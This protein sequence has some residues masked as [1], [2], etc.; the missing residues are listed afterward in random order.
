MKSRLSS[1][2]EREAGN[3]GRAPFVVYQIFLSHPK[4]K[5]W[6]CCGTE[7]LPQDNP[8]QAFRDQLT[9]RNQP[10]PDAVICFRTNI[11]D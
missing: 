10:Q 8:E 5:R 2:S 6:W 3:S 11:Y 4:Y 1:Y 9:E 7:L